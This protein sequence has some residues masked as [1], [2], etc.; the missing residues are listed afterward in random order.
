MSNTVP[1]VVKRLNVCTIYNYWAIPSLF[2]TV[3]K[4][5]LKDK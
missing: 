4:H 3:G 5:W 2:I 1:N